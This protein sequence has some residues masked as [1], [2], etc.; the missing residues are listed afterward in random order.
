VRTVTGVPPPPLRPADGHKGTFGTVLVVAGSDGMLGA[1]ILVATM[2]LRAG[3]GLVQ[4]SL[5]AGLRTGL[6]IALPPATSLQRTR[7]ALA[8]A[9]ERA[10]ALVVGP[11]LGASSATRSLVRWLLA[12]ARVPM[13]L[14][15][16]ALNVL[17]PLRSPLRGPLPGAERLVLTP[18][19]GEAARL[20]AT[21][22][23]A[24]Q[25]DRERALRELVARSGATVV[26]K[27]QGTLVGD[28]K[29]RFR[30][31]TGNPALATGGSGDVLAGLLGSLLAQGMA[32]FDAACLAAFTHG[33]AGDRLR[34]QFGVRGLIASD[35]PLAIVEALR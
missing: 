28:P 22:S 21:T 25:A 16:D 19:P 35:L 33:R 23:Q 1:A 18:H 2:A 29:R 14:D 7:S 6:A 27:G 17:A 9:L 24:I 15:A 11:G 4:V 31:R 10:S 20:L 26:L 5:P 32:P 30:N 3:A 8:A 13:V 12:N 34:R